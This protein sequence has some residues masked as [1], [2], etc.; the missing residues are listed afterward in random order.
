MGKGEDTRQAIL[1][2]A[3]ALASQVGISGLSVGTLAE[4]SGMSKSG[5]FAHFGSKEE[6]QLA[7]VRATQELFL[8]TVMRPALREKRGL[9]R[10]R[11]IVANWLV[12]SR[13]SRLPGGCPLAAAAHEFDGQPGPVRD[14]VAHALGLWRRALVDAVGKCIEAGD[15]RPDTPVDQVAF[16]LNGIVLGSLQDSQL[17]QDPESERRALAAFDRLMSHYAPTPG[18]E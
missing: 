13:R 12:W 17:F 14:E 3:I 1:D 9:P 4:R 2:S 8:E 6:M 16:E 10:L 11:A 15:L 18:K 7:V 5:L